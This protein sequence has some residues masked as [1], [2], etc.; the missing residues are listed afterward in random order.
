MSSVPL[1]ADTMVKIT[2]FTAVNPVEI[3]DE[4]VSVTL[5]AEEAAVIELYESGIRAVLEGK[6]TEAEVRIDVILQ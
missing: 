5:E 2:R 3:Q 1:L 6:H 4:G